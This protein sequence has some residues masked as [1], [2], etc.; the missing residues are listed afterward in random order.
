MPFSKYSPKQKKLAAVANPRNKI[1]GHNK[2]T[3]S[4]E[5]NYFGGSFEIKRRIQI[6]KT[7]RRREKVVYYFFYKIY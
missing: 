5:K 6:R 2:T 7:K 3:K 4:K 1:T